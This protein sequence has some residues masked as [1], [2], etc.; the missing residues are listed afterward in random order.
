MKIACLIAL[1]TGLQFA[2]AAS[3]ERHLALTTARLNAKRLAEYQRRSAKVQA[4]QAESAAFIA[5]WEANC[6]PGTPRADGGC[7]PQTKETNAKVPAV[8]SDGK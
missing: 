8:P 3:P 5:E 2:S 6:K 4:A 7:Q 1:L